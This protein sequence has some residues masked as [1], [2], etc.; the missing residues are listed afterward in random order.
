MTLQFLLD[1]YKVDFLETLVKA[2]AL[3]PTIIYTDE[4]YEQI[5]DLIYETTNIYHPLSFYSTDSDV[6][7]NNVNSKFYVYG[8]KLFNILDSYKLIATPE[9]LNG[10]DI[11]K[12]I[13]PNGQ[14]NNLSYDRV[15]E[16]RKATAQREIDELI[17]N[18][19]G[20][21]EM[22]TKSIKQFLITVY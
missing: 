16:N 12:M 2:N 6:I 15:R 9:E 22:F 3:V 8:L 4:Q 11:I 14:T 13:R 7:F 18:C 21:L 1:N 17:N 19:N 20:V 10:L 5:Y